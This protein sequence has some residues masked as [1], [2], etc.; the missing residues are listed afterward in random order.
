MLTLLKYG[1]YASI[2]AG[3]AYVFV[4]PDRLIS[5][6]EQGKE[7]I[8]DKLSESHSLE[9]ELG[10]VKKRVDGLE[11]EIRRLKKEGIEKKVELDTLHDDVRKREDDL[12]HLRN[13]LEKAREYLAQNKE[14]YNIGGITYT[15]H[16][17]EL[18]AEVKF[19]E[20][21]AKEEAYKALLQTY[22]IKKS[23]IAVSEESVAQAQTL[24]A[25]LESKVRLMS[26][27]LDELRAREIQAEALAYGVDTE[28]FKT[29]LGRAQKSL[30]DLEKKLETERRILEE[31]IAQA[32]G[33]TGG[34]DYHRV[35]VEESEDIGIRIGRHFLMELVKSVSQVAE[36]DD[37]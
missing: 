24:K 12:G 8:E 21:Q 36:S 19:R 20:Y 3:A 33:Q 13:S 27:K 37:N 34:I 35:A 6:A 15:F 29:E 2:L 31:Q 1:F 4:G 26:A 32:P 25:E 10:S 22:N 7:A 16:E 30:N 11:K 23:A 18:D 17:I 14:R 5:Y 9:D 28:D